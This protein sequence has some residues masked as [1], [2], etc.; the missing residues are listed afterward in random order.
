M[1]SDREEAGRLLAEKLTSYKAVQ[2]TAVLAITRGG[3]VVGSS[4]ASSLSLPLFGIVVKKLRAPKNPELAFGAVT[5]QGVKY[6]DWNIALKSEVTQ[7]Y[8][9]EEMR[10][11]SA[12]VTAKELLYR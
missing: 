8:F 7:E 10:K 4:L 5:H 6:I 11:Q 1:F 2:T 9:D 12:E 3:V